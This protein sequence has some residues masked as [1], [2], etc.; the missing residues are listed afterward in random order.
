[1]SSGG[2]RCLLLVTFSAICLGRDRRLDCGAER[3]KE[4]ENK[5]SWVFKKNNF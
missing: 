2:G 4:G 1:M 3:A 5:S